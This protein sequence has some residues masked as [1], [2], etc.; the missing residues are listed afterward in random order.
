MNIQDLKKGDYFKLKESSSIVYVY[1]GYNRMTRKYSAYKF[2]DICA[3]T[4]KKKNY[5]VFINFEF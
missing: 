2:S 3:Y 5:Q 1:D 4:E